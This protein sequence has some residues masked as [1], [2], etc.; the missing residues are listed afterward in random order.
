MQVQNCHKSRANNWCFFY[1]RLKTTTGRSYC[2]FDDLLFQV[3]FLFIWR[4]LC[5]CTRFLDSVERMVLFVGTGGWNSA[6]PIC[7][8]NIC[9]L[10]LLPVMSPSWRAA[11]QWRK[12]FVGE[13]QNEHCSDLQFTLH[14]SVIMY[15]A[16]WECDITILGCGF[17]TAAVLF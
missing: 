10:H 13:E 9:H 11:T 6:L 16:L 17:G 14:S 15:S 3:N 7:C 8:D 1:E 2:L 12:R 5:C 4:L